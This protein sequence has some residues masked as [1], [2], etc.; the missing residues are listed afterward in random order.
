MESIITFL[1]AR[2]K[3]NVNLQKRAVDVSDKRKFL[4]F[5]R[6]HYHESIRILIAPEAIERYKRKI[7]KINVRG[8]GQNIINEYFS[9]IPI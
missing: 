3:L 8:N 4:G 2:L 9:L 7:Q 6:Y 5:N 1:E